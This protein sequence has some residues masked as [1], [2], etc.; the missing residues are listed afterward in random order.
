[1]DPISTHH[2]HTVFMIMAMKC[3]SVSYFAK[4]SI[5]EVLKDTK[6]KLENTHSDMS[7]SQSPVLNRGSQISGGG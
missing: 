5:Y 4:H 7:L 2:L 1:M 3:T 6:G